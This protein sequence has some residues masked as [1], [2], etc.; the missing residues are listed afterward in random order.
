MIQ[1]KKTKFNNNKK[2]F[3]LMD[4]YQLKKRGPH[5]RENKYTKV[6]RAYTHANK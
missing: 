2:V 3:K 1:N 4:K 6:F 5:S